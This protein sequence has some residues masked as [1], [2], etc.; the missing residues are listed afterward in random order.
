M[1]GERTEEVELLWGELFVSHISFSWDYG[2]MKITYFC[3][4][5]ERYR[6]GK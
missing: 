4:T 3:G 6:N 2:E 1:K 5:D